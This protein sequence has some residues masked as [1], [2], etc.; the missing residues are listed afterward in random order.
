MFEPKNRSERYV[1]WLGKQSL[2]PYCSWQFMLVVASLFLSV[3][4]T[5]T[6]WIWRK[7]Q[8]SSDEVALLIGL[9]VVFLSEFFAVLAF[10]FYERRVTY[11]IIQRLSAE[12]KKDVL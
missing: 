10:L 1:L 11:S 6:W 8:F 5:C 2:K 4:L 3:G 12:N 7:G 9:L